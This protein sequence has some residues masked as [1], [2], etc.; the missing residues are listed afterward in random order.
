MT[1]PATDATDCLRETVK[2]LQTESGGLLHLDTVRRSD[3]PRLRAVASAGDGDAADLLRVVVNA[4]RRTDG[5]P[6]AVAMQCVACSAALPPR[7]IAIAVARPA[8]D[9]PQHNLVMA[10]ALCRLC[11]TTPG[12]AGEAATQALRLVWP[13]LRPVK[14][15]HPQGGRA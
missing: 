10:L 4:L 3:L 1:R 14:T 11:A 5:T 6:V 12:I 7:H 2:H 9:N 15:T 13:G 8:T